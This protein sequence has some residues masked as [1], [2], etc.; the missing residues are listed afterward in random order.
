MSKQSGRLSDSVKSPGGFA[1][2]SFAMLFGAVYAR[3]SNFELLQL[4]V[5]MDSMTLYII[6]VRTL[7]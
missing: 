2:I 5:Y 3:K 6:A 4:S 7:L 1:P